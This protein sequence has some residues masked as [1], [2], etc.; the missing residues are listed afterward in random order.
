MTE[1][2]GFE[3]LRFC[4]KFIQVKVYDRFR[5]SCACFHS[6]TSYLFVDIDSFLELF[7]VIRFIKLVMIIKAMSI[8]EFLLLLNVLIRSADE[9]LGF[10]TREELCKESEFKVNQLNSGLKRGELIRKFIRDDNWVLK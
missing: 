2:T 10:L 7:Y 4:H 8:S 9:F 6:S 1:P 5:Q 3:Q